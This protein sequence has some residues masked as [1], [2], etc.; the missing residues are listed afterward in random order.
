[1]LAAKLREEAEELG[2]AR[3]RAEVV[4]ETADVLY[5]ALVAV[6]RGGGTLADVVAEL[7]RRRGLSARQ[8]HHGPVAQIS[9]GS[10]LRECLRKRIAFR[11]HRGSPNSSLIDPSFR[12]GPPTASRSSSINQP[13]R[14]SR[15]SATP[16]AS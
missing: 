8:D 15:T 6:V 13:A 11:R 12:S 16:H 9:M 5:L 4:H 7:S 10:C 3:E 14:C 1:M 2:R